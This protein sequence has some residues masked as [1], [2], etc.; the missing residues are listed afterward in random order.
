[1]DTSSYAPR[2]FAP[3]IGRAVAD[4]TVARLKKRPFE[5]M[6]FHTVELPRD[7][8]VSLDEQ[9]ARYVKN[10][11]MV[12]AGY[13]VDKGDD[14][15]VRITL[16]QTGERTR[17]DWWEV[18]DRV[19]LGNASL[20]PGDFASEM[21][22]LRTHLRNATILMSGRHLQHGDENQRERPFEVFSNCLGYGEKILT[23]EYGPVEIGKIAGETVTVMAGDGAMRSAQI[24]AHGEQDLQ[25]I[26]F[27]TLAGGGG[28]YR[29]DVVATPNHRWVLRDG[30]V[31]SSLKVNDVLKATPAP[32]LNGLDSE[33]VIHGLIYGD[34][35]SN[36]ARRDTGRPGVSQG[37]TY[38]GLR[39]CKQDAVRDEIHQLLDKAG[40]KF[41]TPPHANG[42]RVYYIGKMAYAKE[43]PFTR[44]PEYIAGFIHGWWLADGSKRVKH[45]L[46]VSTANEE[47]AI[48]LIDHAAYA[49]FSVT[50][51]GVLER[52]E[53]DGSYPNGKALHSIRIR[54]D[55]EWKVESIEYEGR[56]EVFCPEEPVTSSFVLA[57]G[58]LTGNCST[59]PLSFLS[60]YLLLNGSG[61]GRDYS[62]DIMAVDF[63]QMP[64]TIPAIREDHPDVVR[65]LAA[66]Y[67]TVDEIEH[68]YQ[69]RKIN[70]FT[71][72]DSREGWAMAL[73]VMETM[74]YQGRRD[75]VLV[76]DF[77]EV[78]EN[79]API[80]G[81]Q[82]RPASGPGPLMSAIVNIAKLRDAGMKPW[83]SALYA[84]HYA[85][86][87]VLVGGARRAARIAT[88]WWRDPDVL[89]F[90]RVKRGGKFLW[91]A[92]NSVLVDA[93]FW[94]LVREAKTSDP[95]ETGD[96]PA[97]A[98][99]AEA[100]FD[101]VM[102]ASYHDGTGEPGFVNADKFNAHID[103]DEVNL[104]ALDVD[105]MFD[106]D[107]LEMSDDAKEML[108][109]VVR[110][111]LMS[112]YP[113]IVNP[114]VT[115]DT[116]VDTVEGPRRVAELIDTPFTALVDGKPYRCETG[117]W[118]TGDKQVYRI[119]TSRGFEV[120]AT[121]NHK[122]LVERNRRPKL[123]GGYNYDREWVEVKDLLA[124]DRIVLDQPD[125]VAGFQGSVD[126]ERGWLLG[127][128]VGDG[129]Y[130][131]DRD[132][133]AYLRFWGENAEHMARMA[134]GFVREHLSP[135]VRFGGAR[136]NATHQS[137][138]VGAACLERLCDGLIQSGTKAGTD[139][140]EQQTPG[141]V[142]GFLCGIFDADGSVQGST[143]KGVSVRLGQSDL[144]RL[145]MVQRMLL[146]LGVVS[147]IYE[148]RREAGQQVLP[149]GNGGS[150]GYETKSQHE[151]VIANSSVEN[152]AQV[153][154]FYDPE[155]KG[156]LSEVL[157]GRK[158]ALNRDDFTSMVVEIVEDGFEAVYDCT[159][160]EAHR[161]SANGLTAHN[162]GEIQLV[163]WGG[164]CIIGDGVPFHASSIEEAENALRAMTRAL[165]RVNLMDALY[166]G[167]VA[168]TNRIGV[169]LTGLHEFAMKFFGYGWHDLV[170]E[171][172]SRDFWETLARF[173]QAVK[174]E[175]KRYATKLGMPVPHTDT[176][177]KPAG[178]TSKLFGLTEGAH[179]PPM[180]TYLRWV[181]FRSDDPLVEEY[182][183]KGYPVKDLKVYDGTTVVGFPTMPTITDLARSLG[184]EHKLV[185]AGEATP[186]EQFE[187]LRLLEK[188]WI[189]GKMQRDTGNQVSYTLKYD[190]A[191]VSFQDYENVMR[192]NLASV[193]C[194]SVMP[195]I[196]VT[197][198]EY[199]PE[200]P[201]TKAEYERIARQ[202]EK[203][204]QRAGGAMEES[205]DL[206]HI[207]CDAG[208]CPVDFSKQGI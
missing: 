208:G 18:A 136:F 133:S 116:W 164:Y 61:V 188:Y 20:N 127:E 106:T 182:R 96:L 31:T 63:A 74:A 81:M 25:R 68:L 198:Y 166:K 120:R 147:T 67:P 111:G 100:V 56:A 69:G 58:M 160:N 15:S 39:V 75:E 178:T 28:K 59:A 138:Q 121:D 84:D 206:E 99:W 184:L 190:P 79:G 195:Q 46:E 131:A 203:T 50:R 83:R 129:G 173:S 43:L 171:E 60:F 17:E 155:K 62:D 12:I 172:K 1:M 10:H 199:Q 101:A 122:F 64:I 109:D 91:S 137:W 126:F 105:R 183:A 205:I 187:Y 2:N 144:D 47:A 179:L 76:L 87:V 162:C 70:Y 145:K 97:D 191:R 30:S 114:C 51:H 186:E 112:Q 159:V 154:G 189:A 49:G 73:A 123:G 194:V 132:Y 65:G 98:A 110:R 23:Q 152:F 163:K 201:V 134:E 185:T 135:D 41:T 156:R 130:N 85:A 204:E 102:N 174:Q 45:A 158:R 29:R 90:I 80:G 24:N 7:D 44:D 124:G 48:W 139:A 181:Q 141:F 11:G 177:I 161:F 180:L 118:K 193:K 94:R 37:R 9:V 150:K 151:L 170:D 169:G 66:G 143:N 146:R 14:L 117:F 88:K 108:L 82:D 192:E 157:R 35:T 13:H 167:E 32:T 200:E 148:K 125:V 107:R 55:V 175:A 38:A 168:R 197:A 21:P 95:V 89:D 27:R 176:T 6:L 53:G 202:I 165:I 77:S 8:T 34:G 5:E 22:D 3:G 207:A 115:G 42:D 36:K 26:T 78:R 57:N 16:Y 140:L 153:V 93:E 92:N 196:D 103:K 86:A 142:A 149:D 54:R 71:V 4:R 119:K 19:A 72:P 33:A 113:M 104:A 128:I 40:Y 52:R